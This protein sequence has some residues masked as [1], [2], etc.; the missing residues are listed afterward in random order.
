MNRKT[1]DQLYSEHTGKVSDKWSL[2]L[3]EYGRLFD[4]YRDKPVRL[5]EIGIQNGGSLEIWSKYFSNASV[6]IGCDINPDCACLTY[7]DP[8]IAV[9]VGDANSGE[10]SERIFLHCPQFDIVIDDGSHLSSDIIR[11]FSLYF[12]RLAEGGLFV[13]E[14]LH[15]SYW[16]QFEGG[17]FDPYSS[18]SFFKR[19][20]DV[21]NHEHW[22]VPKARADIL[23]GIFAKH[24]CD[25][26][27]EVLS[28]VHSVE[29]VNSMCVIRKTAA[30]NNNLG[31]RVIAGSLEPVVP[32]LQTLNNCSYQFGTIYDQSHN[33]WT[34]RTT[35]P[36]EAIQQAELTVTTT[37][38]Q[39]A[40]LEREITTVKHQNAELQRELTAVKHQNAELKREISE[41]Q[42]QIAGLSHEI[43][44]LRNSTSWRITAPLRLAVSAAK[45][46][47]GRGVQQ[48]DMLLLPSPAMT[49][50]QANS[51]P[52]ENAI[53]TAPVTTRAA[54]AS[55]RNLLVQHGHVFYRRHMKGTQLGRLI[56]QQVLK[57]GLVTTTELQISALSHDSLEVQG[58]LYADAT[59]VEANS[60]VPGFHLSPPLNLE[61]LDTLAVRPSINVLLPS[62]RLKDMSGGPNTALLLA[63]LL[64]EKGEQVRLIACDASTEGEE[65]ALFPHL[66]G[67]LQRP[68][69]RDRIELVDAFDRTRPTA[70][71][72][73][74]LFLA[75]A[76]WTAQ[77]AK[78]AV[79]KT[80]HQTFIYLIQDFEPILHEGSTFQARA[81]ETYCLPHIPVINTRLLLDHLVKEGSGRYAEP[82]FAANALWFEPALD[83]N[84]YFADTEKTQSV[85]KKVLL[86]YARPTVA[87]RNLF[88]LGVVALRQAVASGI[89]DKDNW[90]VWAMGEKLTPVALGN[91]VFLSPLPWMNFDAYAERV[92]TADL[93]LSLMLSPH[94]SYPPL[95]MAASGKLVVTN[96]FSVKTAERM[97]ALSPNIIVAEPTAESIAAA[98]ENAAGRINAGLPSYDPSGTVALPSS[99]DESLREIVPVLLR[100]IQTLREAPPD[101]P[102]L[103][104][105][106]PSVPRTRYESYRR[107]CLARRRREGGY[108][109][110]PGL[111]SFVTSAYNTDPVFLEE[112][113]S[114]VF[115]Q[116]GGTQ[117]EWLIL[118][119][120]STNKSTR[121]ALQKLA[122]HPCV[123][124]ERVEENLGIIGGMRFCLEHAR[125]RY[126]L[127]L[128]SDDMIE[129]DCVHVL[130]RFIRD[131]DYPPL[132]YTDEDKLGDGRF[133][134]PYFKPDWD[135]VLFLHSCYIAHQC[136]ID[137]KLGLELGLYSDKTAEGCHDWDSF[138]R[139]MRAGYVPVHI[140]EVLYSWR[141]H[142]ESTS[143]NIASKS[144]ITESHR[145]TLQRFLNHSGISNIELINSP[146]FDYNVD[147]WFRH[148]RVN[149]QSMQTII[150]GSDVLL[151]EATRD[152]SGKPLPVLLEPGSE[153]CELV[154]LIQQSE[155]ELIHIRKQDVIPDD[156]EW[157]WDAMALL[158]LFT[159]SVMVG[160]ILHDG[161]TI[162]DGPRI[163]GFGDGF[164]C[165]DKGR[166][167]SDPGYGAR[168][169]KP[170]TV[171]AV[172]IAHCVVR[173][174]FLEQCLAE[175]QN[176]AV[177]VEMLGP[178]LG[179]LALE[180][181]NR[182]VYSP[183]MR[184]RASSRLADTVSRSAKEH[185]LSRVWSQI[186]DWRV[187]S[188][189]L[190]LDHAKAYVEVE[191]IENQ[192]HLA[193]L[194]SQLLS[195]P[196]WLEMHLRRRGHLYPIPENPPPITLITTVYERTNME[197]LGALAK[198]VTA[199]TVKV[200]EWIIVAHGP[201]TAENLDHIKNYGGKYWGATVI[202][203]ATPLG[204]MGAMRRA[205][206]HAQGEYIVPIDADDVLT[207]D[208]I[209]IL[210]NAIAR[211]NRPDLIYS[212]E[213]L[214]VDGEPAA[215]YLRSAF[216]PVLN[217]DSSYIW[218]LCAINR[219]RAIALELYSDLEATWC[220]DWDSVMRVANAGSRIE[221]V[222]E[223]LYH[224]R[225]H[226][227]ST[228]NKSQ[229]DSR[230][231]DSVRYILE[232]HIT[233]TAAPQRFYVTEW[234]ENRGAP[235]LY[236]A[237]RPD[238]LPQFVWIGD[239]TR[240]DEINCEDDAILVIAANGVVIE[241]RHVFLEVTRLFELHPH[242]GAIGGLVEGKDD[243]VVDGCYVI[244][245]VGNL[246]SPWLGRRADHAGPYAL[247]LK[248]Q[249][250]ATTGHALAFFRISALRQANAWPLEIAGSLSDLMK[251]L[252]VR[253]G[254]NGF[255]VAFSPLVRARANST[256]Q[257]GPHRSGLLAGVSGTSHALGRYSVAREFRSE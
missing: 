33:P 83:R 84:R 24:G 75:T 112:L 132:L 160:G 212:D 253:L 163:F 223:V 241:S 52:T 254:L 30:I 91:G 95:E 204:I 130:T 34:V 155:S 32:G 17:L 149:P 148:K 199:Q 122:R 80:V 15:C 10:I 164:D 23:R 252:C 4:D 129:P 162:V 21:I 231:L 251:H 6:L 16:S 12:P 176:E 206:E 125:G 97:R 153:I 100:R 62:L 166:L 156:D 61:V 230:S 255:T 47:V 44:G 136:A 25:M 54:Y 82:E 215:P 222:P 221:H 141:I 239:A 46:L 70:I 183:F 121:D 200:A 20:A 19:L 123:R 168:M 99:W 201:I 152:G 64:A 197:L 53:S 57:R 214:L 161:K 93:L 170:H 131:N 237:R 193:R 102:S 191:P 59:Q 236:I 104:L 189:R 242:V 248:T 45:T 42:C 173:R 108:Q 114:S 117:F 88:E 219:E 137:R 174:R 147:W 142:S 68:V 234:P 3:T 135:P 76:W 224:W 103:A 89:I 151:K 107:A 43:S 94:P 11:S 81:L 56:G 69:A 240:T 128:D 145:S 235:E 179:A 67:L 22:G 109:Q 41:S 74:D 27:A 124:L 119:N 86:F 192:R 225:Q 232:R 133:G 144:Y 35:P 238:E 165:P 171:S 210:T 60:G 249:S 143:G 92:R 50:A 182:V 31:H 177:P 184:A 220:H 1:L 229:G 49:A 247:A 71:G 110:E 106:F 79:K 134:S 203:E 175:L 250:V 218:H 66:D 198:S 138:I 98:L 90:E 85:G 181:R 202:V 227:G 78:Y 116:D 9:I 115:L 29:F 226:S 209:Q 111:L 185:F 233:R 39:K 146:L 154:T 96:S 196:E 228:T 40:D 190:G 140:P 245:N 36:D 113:A 213:D 211:F 150:I 126:I 205:L 14:D 48:G 178:W 87:R 180:S 28:Q 72:A 172:S 13:A 120:G 188:P 194:Q 18:I 37:L 158:E 65:A 243:V 7:D 26:D 105:A 77:I 167:L 118:D 246:E 208:A 2:Y 207:P 216:D 257:S 256:F 217:L 8:R 244:N 51:A 55:L 195:Y 159:D 139:F 127:P 38:Q 73:H 63:V 58:T 101:I 169:W 187:Y 157:Q 186:P 5:L